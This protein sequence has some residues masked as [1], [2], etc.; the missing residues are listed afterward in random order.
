MDATNREQVTYLSGPVIVDGDTVRDEAWIVDGG[1]TY[2]RPAA[3][4]QVTRIDGW[5]LPGL[6]D[7]H[8][9]VGLDAGG[10]VDPELAAKQAAT[11][12]DAGVL[13]IRDAGSPLD[14]SFV[15]ERRD[16]PRLIRA[17]RFIARP[18]RYIRNYAREIEVDELPRVA[19]EEARK[20]DGWIKLIADWIDRDAGVL[21]PLWPAEVVA[22]AIAAA[23]AEGARV[24][25]HTFLTDAVGPLLDAGIDC[26]EHGTGMTPAH[27][28]QAADQGVAVVPT[29]LQVD[30]F[31]EFAALGAARFPE[32]AAQML[33]MHERRLEQV[34]AMREAGIRLF[35]GTDAGGGL[36]HGLVPQE[37]LEWRKAGIPDDE[38][39]A[40][41][42]W[43]GREYLGAR[44]LT[45]GASADLVVYPSDPREDVG[46]L[47]APRA[48]FLRGERWV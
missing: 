38:I 27:M 48:V 25:A 41:A 26:L 11:D 10:A 42:T 8:C 33:A 1:I 13:L 29:M 24:T 14:T 35:L 6:T 43:G 40:A 9:H 12:R 39:V 36:G 44:T 21:T 3:V 15:H 31:P 46:V 23:H 45:E 20:S 47:S 19:A 16:L 37:A 34:A 2:E 17:A 32:Y 18:K 28:E 5:V 7:F 4:E 22:E 30:R